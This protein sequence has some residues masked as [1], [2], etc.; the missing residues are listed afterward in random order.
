MYQE[1]GWAKIESLLPQQ[2]IF[3]LRKIC[4]DVRENFDKTNSQKDNF[5]GVPLATKQYPELW[6]YYASQYMYDLAKE[7]LE[8]EPFAYNDQVVVKMPNDGFKFFPHY[9]NQ[10][11]PKPYIKSRG[12]N[13]SRP[14]SDGIKTVNCMI[15]L[16]DL[17]DKNGG[18][19][20]KNADTGV[21]QKVYAKAG[22]IIAIDGNTFHQSE[23]N[24]SDSPRCVYACV[25]SAK[26]IK[27]NDFYSHKLYV[28][29]K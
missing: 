11:R 18:F 19:E 17:T 6:Q 12:N 15:I 5:K 2:D 1:K 25:Y 21:W 16:D 4:L 3:N 22:D 26:Q 14:T 10:F 23:V 29:D 20:V 24:V 28:Y 8:T 13:A 7:L 9:D 27:F